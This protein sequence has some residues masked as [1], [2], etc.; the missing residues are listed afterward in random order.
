MDSIK[1][2][3]SGILVF[4]ERLTLSIRFDSVERAQLIPDG[5]GCMGGRVMEGSPLFLSCPVL[6]GLVGMYGRYGLCTYL[7]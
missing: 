1:D 2:L 4:L 5:M 3:G 6:S 7:M